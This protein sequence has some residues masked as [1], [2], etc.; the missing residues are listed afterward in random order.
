[1]IIYDTFGY[2]YIRLH[3]ANNKYNGCKLGITSNIV[4]RDNVYATGEIKRGY[5]KL[6]IKIPFDKMQIIEKLLHYY[7]K[8]LNL[9]I[10][11]DAG[12]EYFKIDIID[13]I[14]PYLEKTIIQFEILTDEDI[15]M[16]TRKPKINKHIL[17]KIN[18]KNLINV[19]KTEKIK[20]KK[21]IYS[22]WD[23]QKDILT[24]T[25]NYFQLNTKGILCL[26]CALGKTFISIWNAQ[27][28][29]ANTVLIGVPN[30]LLLKQWKDD[31]GKLY[32]N[33]NYLLVYGN[34]SSEYI[35]EFLQKNKKKCIIITTY[36][37]S[38]K[39]LEATKKI[40]FK[41][42]MKILDEVHHNT[43][44]NLKTANEGNTYIQILNIPSKY[45]LGLTATLKELN[46]DDENIISNNNEKYFGKII[47]RKSLLWG[48]KKNIVCD[49]VIQTIIAN[50]EQ[51]QDKLEE[52]D[53][54]EECDK[55]LFLSAYCSLKSI[56]DKNSHHLLVYTN[57][58]TNA[59]KIIQYINLLLENNYFDS[60]KD[61]L[62]RSNYHSNIKSKDQKKIID[63]FESSLYGVISCVFCLGEG[64]NF[65]L[66]DGEVFAENMTSNVRIVQSALR[67]GRKNIN[68]PNKKFKIILPILNNDWLHNNEN[69]DLKKIKEI[70]YYMSLEDETII[71]KIKV[72]HINI[73]KQKYK[74]ILDFEIVEDFGYYDEELT[75]NLKLKT[76]ERTQLEITY[77]KSRKIIVENKIK[78]KTEYLEFCDKD[79]RLSKE[80]E[81][82]Y[83]NQF[84]NW[85]DYLSINK[86]SFYDFE[87]CKEKVNKLLNLQPQ[88]K[89]KYLNLSQ[90]VIQLCSLDKNFPP[91]DLWID[92]YNC[93]NL[94]EIIKLKINK[95]K[96][97]DIFN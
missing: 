59:D 9:Y 2:L 56:S 10:I 85:L 26:I 87:T 40:N 42:D 4:D 51:L 84:T 27:Q 30:L 79:T 58:K 47:D 80:P 52:F 73:E 81:I 38:Y 93:K 15:N 68:E 21:I 37:S 49:Y 69:S 55:R 12:T 92:C 65:P 66:L 31:I 35:S 36:A 50:E 88:I 78:N 74:S 3:E 94:S 7:F 28:L 8:S 97:L 39:V 86:N 76:T 6:V 18:I 70:V 46:Y 11:L 1:M 95:K 5:Y 45:Q 44:T 34:I 54:I 41:F 53:I 43:S 23:Y 24:N 32:Q 29:D 62:F 61:K 82:L 72:N 77:E 19:L 17:N 90:I 33:I 64:W 57:N 13:L 96:V 91:A 75:N 83:K 63:T 71:Q 48:I 89:N 25:K 60:I 22:P 20:N 67:A 16:L 14:I